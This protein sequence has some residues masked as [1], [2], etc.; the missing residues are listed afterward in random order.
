[1]HIGSMTVTLYRIEVVLVCRPDRL[2]PRMQG[3]IRKD[4][5]RVVADER[6]N[7]API[8]IAESVFVLYHKGS[9]GRC[10]FQ[11]MFS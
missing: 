8:L 1:M 4:H 7:G 9:G 11:F 2:F 5:Y 10:H 3:A 6:R